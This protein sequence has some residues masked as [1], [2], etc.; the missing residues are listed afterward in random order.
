MAF[1]DL[2][3]GILG[4][5]LS[6]VA[7]PSLAQDSTSKSPAPALQDSTIWAYTQAANT[8]ELAELTNYLIAP[9]D[10]DS[11][12]VRSI[13]YWLIGHMEVELSDQ[14]KKNSTPE[15]TLKSGSGNSQGTCPIGP[16]PFPSS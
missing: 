2:K 6:S 16:T 8:N 15:Q 14:S 4:M 10:T 13:Y 12:R 3:W 9:Y 1:L 11:N 7:L 5:L